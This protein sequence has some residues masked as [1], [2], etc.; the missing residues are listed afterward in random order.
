[1]TSDQTFPR[2]DGGDDRSAYEDTNALS[3][4]MADHQDVRELF[5]EYEALSANAADDDD[6]ETA[7][8]RADLAFQICMALTAHATIEEELFYPAARDALG[9]ADLVDA[10][11][12]EHAQARGLIEQIQTMAAGDERFDGLV[13]Q[14]HEAIEEHVQQE[15]GE[16]F[17]RVQETDLDLERLGMEMAQRRDEVLAALEAGDS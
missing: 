1:M 2:D 10:A 6:G 3:L 14:L 11:L 17:P 12:A 8:D 16:L 7:A 4:L 9:E 13:R 15:E 5:T